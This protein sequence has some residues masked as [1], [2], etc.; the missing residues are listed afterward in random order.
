MNLSIYPN[1]EEMGAA[2]ARLGTEAIRSA[3]ANRGSANILVAT[4]SSQFEVLEHLVAESNI[5]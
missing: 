3:I 1:R 4:G 5:D 2:A